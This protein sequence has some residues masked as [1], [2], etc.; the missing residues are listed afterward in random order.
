M[1]TEEEIRAKLAKLEAD[2]LQILAKG[3]AR[4]ISGV[5]LSGVAFATLTLKCDTLRWVLGEGKSE[6]GII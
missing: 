5:V 6:S 2:R 4:G 1:H 3:R